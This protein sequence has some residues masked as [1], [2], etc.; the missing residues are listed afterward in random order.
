LWLVLA[1]WAIVSNRDTVAESIIKPFV[2]PEF[3]ARWG[4]LTVTANWPW[5]V[6]VIGSLLILVVAVAETSYR[7]YR[8]KELELIELQEAIEADRISLKMSVDRLEF[9]SWHSIRYA[10]ARVRI[11][12]GN[13]KV[14]FRSAEIII[15]TLD[16]TRNVILPEHSVFTATLTGMWL[17]ENQPHEARHTF[18]LPDGVDPGSLDRSRA[19]LVLKDHRDD[20]HEGQVTA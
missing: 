9:D 14:L 20:I 18:R 12:N 7:L 6:W 4:W 10:S 3:W 15:R 5:Y 16:D 17:N 13:R 1:A 2:S 8:R 19:R 11:E